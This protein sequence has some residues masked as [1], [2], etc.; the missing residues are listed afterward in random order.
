MED[1]CASEAGLWEKAAFLHVL[2]VALEP[3]DAEEI[4]VTSHDVDHGFKC[5]YCHMAE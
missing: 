3:Q 1:A 5:A 4:H 2:N